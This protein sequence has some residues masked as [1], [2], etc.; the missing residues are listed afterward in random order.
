MK[1]LLTFIIGFMM[2]ATAYA[3]YVLTLKLTFENGD[4]IV[5]SVLND[6]AINHEVDYENRTYKINVSTVDG[7]KTYSIN[8]V[9]ALNFI[10]TPLVDKI[11]DVTIDNRNTHIILS[12]NTVKI[13]GAKPSSVSIH[14]LNARK[15]SAK[16]TS[17]EDGT[18]VDLS[19][20]PKG[21]Y[22]IKANK[23][24]FKITK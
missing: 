19:S 12:G 10:E 13:V 4:T 8:D 3:G 22:I 17:T 24:S 7:L 18:T 23:Q 21:I 15:H 9:K 20:L 16:I 1:K 2:S 11:D 6:V 5:A 14:D